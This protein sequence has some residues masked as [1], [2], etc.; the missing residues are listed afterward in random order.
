VDIQQT[1]EGGEKEYKGTEIIKSKQKG[2]ERQMRKKIKN[3]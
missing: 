3:E 1:R 2:N